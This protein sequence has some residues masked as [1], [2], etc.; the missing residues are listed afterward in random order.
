MSG[1]GRLRRLVGEATPGPWRTNGSDV[2]GRRFLVAWDL[3]HRDAAYIAAMNPEVGRALLDVVGEARSMPHEP[4]CCVEV[5]GD[6]CGWK[7][8]DCECNRQKVSRAVY[9][10]DALLDEQDQA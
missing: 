2:H 6:C 3:L 7:P 5:H 9:A 4:W 10:L 8:E 1:T